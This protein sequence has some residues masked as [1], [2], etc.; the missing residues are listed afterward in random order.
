M[1]IINDNFKYTKT[2]VLV[3]VRSERLIGVLRDSRLSVF[4]LG[5]LV[6]V[7][8]KDE[9][10]VKVLLNRLVE[11]GLLV[12]VERNKYSLPGQSVFSVAS[13]L[14]FPSY[15]SFISAYSYY[16]LTA[17]IPSTV[18]I[19]CLR[20]RKEVFYEGCR[21][22]F[23]KFSRR[24]FFGYLREYVEGKTVFIA[25]VE[26]AVLD[27]LL[28]PRYCP[29]S[30][31]FSALREAGLNRERLLEYAVRL[32]SRAVVKRLGYLLELAG[33]DL[34]PFLKSLVDKNYELLNP[35]KPSVG[36]RVEKWR[37]IVNEVLE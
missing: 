12:R 3:F 37:L 15:V 17:Q 22:R 33:L 8:N 27:S 5:D 1:V 34:Y 25:E 28:L 19:V 7:L 32:G 35:L 29:V 21:V 24:R 6:R 23:V 18:F 36:E 11:R 4:S 2:A 31:T 26:K 14:V 13:L 30:E 20:Q 16:G 10:Y 9:G